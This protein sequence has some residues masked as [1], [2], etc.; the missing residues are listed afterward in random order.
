MIEWDK[1]SQ[2]NFQNLLNETVALVDNEKQFLMATSYRFAKEAHRKTQKSK[3]NV[4]RK[5]FPK[6]GGFYWLAPANSRQTAWKVVATKREAKYTP[7]GRGMHK[8]AWLA[9][10]LKTPFRF[11]NNGT[12]YRTGIKGAKRW[13]KLASSLRKSFGFT[14]KI[15]M[16]NFGPAITKMEKGQNGLKKREIM[17]PAMARTSRQVR[18]FYN[19][20]V[21][22]MKKKGWR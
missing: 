21:R 1:K 16:T 19:G 3:K 12:I 13:A 18:F 4:Y 22:A 17:K 5:F 9:A 15:E 8:L 2:R 11:G 6:E 14:S 7:R 20:L 10:A